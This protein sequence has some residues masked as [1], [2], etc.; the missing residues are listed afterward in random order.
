MRPVLPRGRRQPGRGG[1]YTR[2]QPGWASSFDRADSAPSST[3]AWRGSRARSL[4]RQNIWALD[5]SSGSRATACTEAAA[6]FE[7]VDVFLA[8]FNP[9]PSA[10]LIAVTG[11]VQAIASDRSLT[12]VEMLAPRFSIGLRQLQRVFRAYVGVSPKWVIQRY[13]LIE[14]AERVVDVRRLPLANSEN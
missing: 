6:A 10:E 5:P 3:R 2:R 1:E 4:R 14:A 11:I 12:R 8:Q 7:H 13:R 9:T